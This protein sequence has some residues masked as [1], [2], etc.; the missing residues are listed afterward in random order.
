MLQLIGDILNL[1]AAAIVFPLMMLP[2]A[3]HLSRG[4]ALAGTALFVALTAVVAA[5][6]Y[7]FAILAPDLSAPAIGRGHAYAGATALALALAVAL[8]GGP[9]GATAALAP[10]LGSVARLA[11]RAAMWLVLVMALVQFAVVILRYVF[12]VNSIFMQE[13]VVYMHGAVFL[14]AGGYALITDDHVRVDIFYRDASPRKKALFDL[15]GTYLLLFPTCLLILWTASPYVAQSWLVREG[16][17]E[18][19]GIQAL[20]LLKSCIPAFALLLAMA[21][22]SLA[23]RASKTL[24]EAA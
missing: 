22:F 17:N 14:L 13:G 23:H 20:Y 7:I 9:A 1:A 18:Q 19:S 10:A 5:A 12:G 2:L 16:S 21:G 11:G 24:R 4:R 8:A 15:A 6:A 3:A